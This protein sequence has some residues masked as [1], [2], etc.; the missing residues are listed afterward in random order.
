MN[1]KIEKRNFEKLNIEALRQQCG[2]A[3]DDLWESSWVKSSISKEDRRAAGPLQEIADGI[4]A[5]SDIVVILAAGESGRLLRAVTEAAPQKED[6]AEV[7]V[8]GDT[9]S[10]DSYAALFDRLRE[11]SFSL[12]AVS[13]GE[14]S[15]QLRGAYACLKELL[16]KQF[17]KEQSGNRICVIAGKESRTFAEDAGENDWPLINYPQIDAA[18]GANTSAALL[19]LALKGADLTEYLEGFYEMLASPAWDLHGADYALGRA[20]WLK[21]HKTDSTLIWH[22]QLTAVG[23]WRQNLIFM[24]EEEYKLQEESFETVI[25]VERE[26]EDIMMPFFEGCNE[27]GSLNLLLASEMERQFGGQGA[28]PKVRISA[29]DLS[30]YSLGQ[31]FAFIQLSAGITEYLLK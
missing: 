10:A 2:S 4:A 16:F 27:D 11:Q 8:F 1:I 15:L 7:I 19:A 24:P 17:G 31:L 21:E 3:L 25:S 13:P 29:E 22:K 30:A 28:G 20:A 14:E 6:R 9:F 23:A 18:Y 12:V 26:E 5:N